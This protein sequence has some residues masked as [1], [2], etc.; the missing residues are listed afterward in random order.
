M[1]RKNKKNAKNKKSLKKKKKTVKNLKKRESLKKK[2]IKKIEKEAVKE[3]KLPEQAS[4]KKEVA[5]FTEEELVEFKNLLLARKKL[6]EEL[7]ENRERDLTK[8]SIK[9]Q[10][11]SLSGTPQHLAEIGGEEYD[12]S[13][14]AIILENVQKELK[15]II[16]ALQKIE[17][18]E[19]GIC[20]NCNK[21][22]NK[23]RLKALPYTR[24]CLD[25]KI[26]EENTLNP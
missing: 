22:I 19:Y 13:F 21:P 16:V 15:E 26:L 23:E 3:E 17:R 7:L 20:E 9:D 1:P 10:T 14:S 6:I 11:G 25:C 4:E 18:K 2:S 5:Y 8:S 24:L 12:K